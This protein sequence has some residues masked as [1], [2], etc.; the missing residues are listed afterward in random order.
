LTKHLEKNQDGI[1]ER[2][3]AVFTLFRKPSQGLNLL[4]DDR[5]VDLMLRY[6]LGQLLESFAVKRQLV[7]LDDYVTRTVVMTIGEKAGWNTADVIAKEIENV[8]TTQTR[9]SLGISFQMLVA[10]ALCEFSGTIA[11]LAQDVIASERQNENMDVLPDWATRA[12]LSAKHYVVC[13]S[14][15]E[16][17]DRLRRKG[18]FMLDTLIQPDHMRPDL[19]GILSGGQDGASFALAVSAKVCMNPLGGNDRMDD[20]AST[21]LDQAYLPKPSVRAGTVRD[22]IWPNTYE[23][24]R[25]YTQGRCLRLHVVLGNYSS[26]REAPED[27]EGVNGKQLK[28]VH[29]DGETIRVIIHEGNCHALFQT[30]FQKSL[31]STLMQKQ[32]PSGHAEKSE[33]QRL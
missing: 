22:V 11:E 23:K 29:V 4:L 13:C 6:G 24:I 14:V 18:N 12:S 10:S 28:T 17:N 7:S 3:F 2:L 31:I 19:V 27:A 20:L 33:E 9:A 15:V 21:C 25:D 30:E 32:R 1:L 26:Y 5:D 16:I 8:I